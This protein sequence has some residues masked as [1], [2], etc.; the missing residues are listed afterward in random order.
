MNLGNIFAVANRLAVLF[1][2]RRPSPQAFDTPTAMPSFAVSPLPGVDVGDSVLAQVSVL[3][4]EVTERYQQYLRF[5]TFD[6]ADWTGTVQ[7]DFTFGGASSGVSVVDAPNARAVL[8]AVAEQINSLAALDDFAALVDEHPPTS[9]PR[10]VVYRK[11][12]AVFVTTAWT[13]S[14]PDKA[15]LTTRDAASATLDL[16]LAVPTRQQAG[17]R[18]C[19]SPLTGVAVTSEGFTDRFNVAGYGRAYARLRDVVGETEPG[20]PASRPA[21]VALVVVGPCVSEVGSVA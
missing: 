7:V 3:P 9:Q 20:D 2:G 18:W 14:G 17:L 12:G 21:A 13:I 10:L 16:H 11:D 15:P 1:G 4:R 6:A 8:E 19:R 5:P